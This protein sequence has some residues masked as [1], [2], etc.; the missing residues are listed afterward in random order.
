MKTS[1]IAI[2]SLA[3]VLGLW[4]SAAVAEVKLDHT[5]QKVVHKTGI[6]GADETKLVAADRA[7]PGDELVYTITFTNNGAKAVDAGSVVITNPIPAELDYLP[8]TAFGSGT[9]VT[10]STDGGKT[11]AEPSRLTAVVDGATVTAPVTAYTTIRWTFAPALAPGAS[12]SVSFH[13]RLK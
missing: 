1:R 6:G 12:S 3:L 13:A 4:A 5:I 8:G 11:F 7:V 9:S 2:H 10:F